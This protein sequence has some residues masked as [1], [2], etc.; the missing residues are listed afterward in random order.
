M[1]Y[2]CISTYIHQIYIYIFVHIEFNVIWS[3]GVSENGM[4]VI[5]T[6]MLNLL[7]LVYCTPF[8]GKPR[9]KLLEF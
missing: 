2:V 6:S 5:F 3:L 9:Q 7:I 1:V 8:F 4:I